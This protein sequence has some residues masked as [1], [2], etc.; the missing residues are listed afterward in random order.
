MSSAE[1]TALEA[2]RRWILDEGGF[3]HPVRTEAARLALSAVIRR[4]SLYGMES[5]FSGYSAREL[6]QLAVMVDGDASARFARVA[7]SRAYIVGEEAVVEACRAAGFAPELHAWHDERRCAD[8]ARA[9]ELAAS[10]YADPEALHATR[11]TV[12]RRHPDLI[13]PGWLWEVPDGVVVIAHHLA[14][15]AATR[16]DLTLA[17]ADFCERRRAA[18][19]ADDPDG[20]LAPLTETSSVPPQTL[21]RPFAGI[22]GDA[23]VLA[24]ARWH[25]E[26]HEPTQA[27]ALAARIRDLAPESDA[28]RLV[29]VHGLIAGGDLAGAATLRSEILD[30][31]VA[32]Q[33][34]LALAAARPGH[35]GDDGLVAIARRCT[36]GEPERFLAALRLLLDRRRLDLARTV[37]GE[38]ER[39]A[40]HPVLAQV[41]AALGRR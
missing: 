22:Y 11:L 3:G 38:G 31:P 5:A 25:L 4:L 7:L 17:V 13:E 1:T 23:T 39:F 6:L 40:G 12:A 14:R 2:L 19:M 16:A 30:P 15:I 18:L 28:A 35:L 9:A 37:A 27:I 20:I 41:F 33:A 24:A 26:H 10:T 36:A 32:D 21:L 29:V 34:D 8:R